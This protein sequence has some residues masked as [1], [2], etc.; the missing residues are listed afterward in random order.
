M[1]RQRPR[2]DARAALALSPDVRL[3]VWIGSLVPVKQPPSVRDL[4]GRGAMSDVRLVL[5][6][7]GHMLPT[8]RRTVR[9][10]HCERV[11]LL[12]GLD[13]AAVATGRRPPMSS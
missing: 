1:L 8:V 11:S 5:I 3:V 10:L 9:T 12:G 7:D 4:V 2:T 13:S 6:G